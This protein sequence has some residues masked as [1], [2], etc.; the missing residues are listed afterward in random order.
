MQKNIWMFSVVFL[1]LL[2][3]S[4]CSEEAAD[5]EAKS[6]QEKRTEENIE[7]VQEYQEKKV[8][9]YEIKNPARELTEIEKVMLRKPGEFSGDYYDEQKVNEKLEKRL[10][11][12]TVNS[13]T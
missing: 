2:I 12:K 4:A 1:L 6:E 3:L 10:I 9:Y 5:G 7:E 13:S 8:E 11:R